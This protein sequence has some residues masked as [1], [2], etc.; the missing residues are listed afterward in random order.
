MNTCMGLPQ[1]G[2]WKYDADGA[3]ADRIKKC[4]SGLHIELLLNNG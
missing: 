3:D 2:L 4:H 1:T